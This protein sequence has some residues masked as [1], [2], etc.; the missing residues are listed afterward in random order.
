M[1][2]SRVVVKSLEVWP[3]SFSRYHGPAAIL[4]FRSETG[5]SITNFMRIGFCRSSSQ[6][7][8][9]STS[10]SSGLRWRPSGRNF[11]TIFYLFVL[12]V[13]F[14]FQRSWRTG[15]NSRKCIW[16][17]SDSIAVMWVHWTVKRS[18]K[19]QDCPGSGKKWSC[20]HV[21]CTWLW[22]CVQKSVLYWSDSW[23]SRSR[24]WLEHEGRVKSWA[25]TSERHQR[26]IVPMCLIIRISRVTLNKS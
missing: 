10:L 1:K 15:T 23:N 7:Y 4:H 2:W 25:R 22:S 3:T 20:N 9:L 6:I 13:R 18:Q 24:T 16:N 14:C 11:P 17:A 21:T 19:H 12:R 26:G 8:E 5:G